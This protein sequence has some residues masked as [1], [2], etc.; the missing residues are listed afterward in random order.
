MDDGPNAGPLLVGL[1]HDIL[2]LLQ[3]LGLVEV[4]GLDLVAPALF[5]DCVEVLLQGGV[6]EDL[7]LLVEGGSTT[8]EEEGIIAEVLSGYVIGG[9]ETAEVVVGGGG[10]DLER[11]GM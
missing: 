3:G 4:A 1:L 9:G 6:A 2:Q 10:E 7:S 11:V 8:E 5:G